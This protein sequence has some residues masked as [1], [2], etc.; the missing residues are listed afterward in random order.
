MS[1]GP[2]Y[3]SRFG[4][5]T[6]TKVFVGGL[7]WET[8]SEELRRHFEQFGDI[9]EAVVIT[10]KATGRSKGYG[11]V[12][13]HDAEAARRAVV[14]PNPVIDGR[15]ANCSIAALAVP[16]NPRREQGRIQRLGQ[17]GSMQQ[18]AGPGTAYGRVPA[19]VGP[20]GIHSTPY[21]FMAYPSEYG[22]QQAA[23][24]Y[25]PQMGSYYYQQI[26]GPTSSSASV[27]P[28]PMGYPIQMHST[29]V[30]FSSLGAFMQ[31]PRSHMEGAHLHSSSDH[32]CPFQLQAPFQARQ[33]LNP[34]LGNSTNFIA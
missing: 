31:Y 8:P 1:G 21:G 13:F 32:Y 23:A 16:R 10:D 14:N 9:L 5:T 25:S 30:G 3:R 4:D 20:Q 28:P 26:Y 18:G 6:W 24:V 2:H 29:R 27:G 11:F 7:A 15:R 34:T 19:Q 33:Q 22:Y 17:E 12:T